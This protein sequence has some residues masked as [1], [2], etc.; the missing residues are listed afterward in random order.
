MSNLLTHAGKL[1]I[2]PLLICSQSSANFLAHDRSY[3]VE[4]LFCHLCMPPKYILYAISVPCISAICNTSAISAERFFTRIS[5]LI[6]RKSHGT[7]FGDMHIIAGQFAKKWLKRDAHFR[8]KSSTPGDF[9]PGKH[10]S[11]NGKGNAS[12]QGS[13][14][15]APATIG[16]DNNLIGYL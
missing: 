10:M 13:G 11:S 12:V 6:S 7:C 14:T 3:S 8:A 4:F 9:T 1:F 2:H 16:Q 5:S 15:D